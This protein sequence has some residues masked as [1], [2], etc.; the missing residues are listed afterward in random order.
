MYFE[1]AEGV[2]LGVREVW[3]I[4]GLSGSIETGTRCH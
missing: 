1:E 3:R 2:E 4:S